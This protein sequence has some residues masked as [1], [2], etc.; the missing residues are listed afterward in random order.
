MVIIEMLSFV[1]FIE[2]IA[3]KDRTVPAADVERMRARFGD[4]LGHIPEDGSMLVPV[5][6]VLEALDHWNRKRSPKPPK[7]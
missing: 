5:D 1:Q 4:K 6:C 7:R 3:Q 2:E